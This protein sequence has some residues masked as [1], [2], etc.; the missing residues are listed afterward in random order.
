MAGVTTYTN[1]KADSI[2]QLL[3]EGNSLTSICKR[4]KFPSASTVFKWLIEQESFSEK[5]TRAREA[6]ADYLAAEILDIA[7]QDRVTERVTVKSNG[8]TET[9]TVDQVDRSRLMVDA[10]KWYASKLAPKKYGDKIDLNHGGQ[11]NNPISAIQ[12]EIIKAN[13]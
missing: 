8:D 7:G 10:R 5:Y 9:V 12:I 4:D 3:S 11:P 13:G 2:C 1:E 6:Q